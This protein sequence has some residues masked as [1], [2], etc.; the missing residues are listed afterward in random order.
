[1]GAQIRTIS[2]SLSL[3]SPI[4]S[5]ISP[6]VGLLESLSDTKCCSCCRRQCGEMVGKARSCAIS[7]ISAISTING[8]SATIA[9]SVISKMKAIRVIRDANV[10]Y[11]MTT[12]SMIIGISSINAIK[13]NQVGSGRI[14][15]RTCGYW[16]TDTSSSVI[17]R[18]QPFVRRPLPI[19][20]S[21][22]S[23][24]SSSCSATDRDMMWGISLRALLPCR[25]L[26]V[27]LK[28]SLR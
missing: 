16:G 1:M 14:R 24:L 15:S 22:S 4:T 9:I 11:N 20:R 13:V 6:H 18:I 10:I 28:I 12:I 23:R 8:V 5:A 2:L 19:L 27:T 25:K 17:L 3:K 21:K 26:P 7:L